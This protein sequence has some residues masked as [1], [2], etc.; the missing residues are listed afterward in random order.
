MCEWI[1][2]EWIPLNCYDYKSTCG[3]KNTLAFCKQGCI[4]L[5][6]R[7]FW[8]KGRGGVVL[9]SVTFTKKQLVQQKVVKVVITYV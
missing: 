5:S 2:L 6:N 3:A 7:V 8:G 9:F 1:E 4:V